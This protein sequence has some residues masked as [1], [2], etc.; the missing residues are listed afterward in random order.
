MCSL[1]HFVDL[2]EMVKFHWILIYGKLSQKIEIP[3]VDDEDSD[4]IHLLAFSLI[5]EY[6][7]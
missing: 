7:F 4:E 1:D 5:K 6:Y 3:E 2:N